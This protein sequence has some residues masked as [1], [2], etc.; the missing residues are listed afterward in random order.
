MQHSISTPAHE[1]D[2]ESAQTFTVLPA[3][4]PA[5]AVEVQQRES[6]AGV[7]L[8]LAE[9]EGLV[10]FH[11]PD[12]EGF[13]SFQVA[14]HTETW[15]LSSRTFQLWLKGL[16][17]N[18]ERRPLADK[19]FNETL[20]IL[21]AKAI[22]SGAEHTTHLRV[23]EHEGVYYLDLTDEAWRAVKITA[24]GWEVIS[25]PPVRFIR[26]RAMKALPIPQPG[27]SLEDL[28]PFVN[29]NDDDW[30]LV[31]GWLVAA[32]RPRGPYPML[33]LNG[34]QGSAKSTTARVLR[35]LVD[36]NATPLRSK[37]R[38][39][40][41]LMLTASNSHTLVLDNLSYISHDLSDALCRISTGG[42]L[43]RRKL[44][45]DDEEAI[46][47]VLRPMLITGITDMVDRSD[48]L[49][50]SI[51]L[52]LPI[53]KAGK[54]TT[55]DDFWTAFEKAQPLILGALLNAVATGLAR[56]PHTRLDK[57]PRL[58]DFAVWATAC[59]AG[60]GL[61]EGRFMQVYGANLDDS[62]ARVLEMSPVASAIVGLL[63]LHRGEVTLSPTE[64][65][66]E[67]NGLVG[68][69]RR[70]PDWP[71]SV[72]KLSTTLKRLAPNLREVGIEY[73]A[74]KTSGPNS[75][76]YVRLRRVSAAP[77]GNETEQSSAD[78]SQN[79]LF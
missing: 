75:S 68:D 67:L 70:Q 6:Q 21:K 15:A 44:F 5:P 20:S 42:G 51:V 33:V 74:G 27:G 76:R 63:D 78:D 29:V 39:E 1:S 26:N 10:L 66:R 43:S 3:P 79:L 46:F 50:R 65:Y 32:M 24:A 36:P 48:L 60:L 64:L 18:A 54:R 45:T 4:D 41:D 69:E 38:N 34:E 28:R 31:L 35:A 72:K 49:S 30:V 62:N 71:K 40:E 16:Y 37:P 58:A 11:T 73:E 55:E 23:A 2:T 22:Y 47:N 77:L 52:N 13:A 8:K 7:A 9:A 14:G 56:L 61:E 17:F 12:Q 25:E 57:L 19:A 59:E 53:I